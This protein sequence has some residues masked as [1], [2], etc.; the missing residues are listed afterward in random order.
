MIKKKHKAPRDEKQKNNKKLE[1]YEQNISILRPNICSSND[2]L[3]TNDL[4]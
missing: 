2:I 4:L 3:K 1:R